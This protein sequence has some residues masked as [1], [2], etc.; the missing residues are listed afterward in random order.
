MSTVANKVSAV[1]PPPALTLSSQNN[2]DQS[3]DATVAKATSLLDELYD[4]HTSEVTTGKENEVPERPH[5]STTTSRSS[6]VS[7]TD[8]TSP[9]NRA[10]SVKAKDIQRKS[11]APLADNGDVSSQELELAGLGEACI[12]VYQLLSPLVLLHWGCLRRVH[13]VWPRF[14]GNK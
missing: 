13:Y 5:S 12:H 3:E 7:S 9:R 4:D 8:S 1:R 10:V 14:P 11:S 6:S 2:I